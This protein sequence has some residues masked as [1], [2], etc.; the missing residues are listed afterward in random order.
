M[1]DDE[2]RDALVEAALPR[3]RLRPPLGQAVVLLLRQV[4]LRDTSRPA[5]SDRRADRRDRR[6]AR[7]RRRA[8]RRAGARRRR[9]RGLCRS[10]L[11]PPVPHDPRR[12]EGVRDGESHRGAVRGG[13][14]R[15][16]RRGRRHVRRSPPRGGRQRPARPVS[17][18]A[19]RCASST[20][21]RAGRTLSRA[22]GC[23]SVRSIGQDPCCRGRTLPLSRPSIGM[24]ERQTLKL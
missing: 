21:K 20:A 23:A 3:R 16:L 8:A 14:D 17:S 7:A 12:G 5:R 18:C 1:T 4:P 9:A 22:K 13:R 6:R 15:V 10:R 24:V 11:G 19:R 2:L